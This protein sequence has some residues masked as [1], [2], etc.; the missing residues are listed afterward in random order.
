MMDIGLLKVKADLYTLDEP[1]SYFYGVILMEE[2]IE[3]IKQKLSSFFLSFEICVDAF[4]IFPFIDIVRAGIETWI[5][6]L[7]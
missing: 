1:Q 4:E 5:W 3:Q 2:S 6:K 7:A